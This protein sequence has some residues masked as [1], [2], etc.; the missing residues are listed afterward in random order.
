MVADEVKAVRD[1]FSDEEIPIED[2]RT[3][4]ACGAVHD[5]T[6]D[7]VYQPDGA[8]CRH[9]VCLDCQSQMPAARWSGIKRCAACADEA[10]P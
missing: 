8:Y 2:A 3:C 1:T 9:F 10:R 7:I 4:D 5:K 6:G